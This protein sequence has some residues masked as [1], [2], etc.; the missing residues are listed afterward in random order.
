MIIISK[1]ILYHRQV[2]YINI[3]LVSS[4]SF[5]NNIDIIFVKTLYKIIF[6]SHVFGKTIVY[7][8]WAPVNNTPIN[9]SI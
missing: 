3:V 9:W 8:Y 6:T 5:I 7:Y 1:N 4:L 2:I